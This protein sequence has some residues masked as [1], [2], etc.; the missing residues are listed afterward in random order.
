MLR[1]PK[2]EYLS[3]KSVEEGCSLL[4]EHEGKVKAIA[5]GTDVLPSLKQRLFTP[6]HILDLGQIGSLRGIKNGSKE[7]VRI[8][9]LTTLTA[10]EEAS[11]VKEAKIVL[12]AVGPGPIA[13]AEAADCMRGN[14]IT[15]EV[16]QAVGEA[17]QKA[18]H[19]VGN[20]ISTPG[21]RRKM[22]AVMAKRAVE[23]SVRRAKNRSRT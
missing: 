16:V 4:Q 23:E 21:Y 8:G 20:T 14:K 2:F 1:L 22:A 17:A 13:V 11:L 10:I 19:P 9:S 15:K 6:E 18:A 12:G 7:E 3:P 5:G